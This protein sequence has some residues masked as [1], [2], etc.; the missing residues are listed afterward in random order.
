MFYDRSKLGM[1]ALG[2]FEKG[3]KISLGKIS[4]KVG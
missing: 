1:A 2:Y 3:W 4:T